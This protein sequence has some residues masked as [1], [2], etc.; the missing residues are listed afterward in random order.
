[1]LRARRA[2]T[3][4]AAYSNICEQRSTQRNATLTHHILF[5]LIKNALLAIKEAAK[6]AITIQLKPNK[7][8]NTLVFTDTASGIAQNFLCIILDAAV[9]IYCE[10]AR[11]RLRN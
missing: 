4:S 2:S 9:E 1:L 7:E 8:Y 5:N 10:C 3:S 11:E 6:G